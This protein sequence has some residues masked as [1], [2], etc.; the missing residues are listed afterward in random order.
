MT[1]RPHARR[2]LSTIALAALAWSVPL[3]AQA[4]DAE[5][6]A[7]A[8]AVFDRAVDLMAKKRASDACPLFEEVTRLNPTGI[9]AK[10]ELAKC[11]EATKRLASAWEMFTR[12]EAA[13]T[14]AKQIDRAKEAATRAA[15][16]KPR[17]SML[18]LVGPKPAPSSLVVKRDGV[19]V[20]APLWGLPLPVDGGVHTVTASADGFSAFSSTVTVAD[21]KAALTVTIPTLAAN[22]APVAAAAASPMAAANATLSSVAVI[23]VSA[24]QPTSPAPLEPSHAPTPSRTLPWVMT[25]GGIAFVVT[26]IGLGIDGQLAYAKLRKECPDFSACGYEGTNNLNSRKDRDLGLSIG[27]GVSGAAL[28]TLGFMQLRSKNTAQQ[29]GLMPSLALTPQGGS[30]TVHGGF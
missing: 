24:G 12:V 9:G 7:A 8:Q 5:K 15:Q 13:A 19:E 4:Q 2:A 1:P 20:G 26:A 28:A 17:L 3:T 29:V 6:R 23:P 21:E 30:L 16:L 14:T 25:G 22:A 10:L 18:T 11:Y 27:F